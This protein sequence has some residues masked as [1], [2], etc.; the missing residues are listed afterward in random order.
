M[1][2]LQGNQRLYLL[3]IKFVYG[4]A[5]VELKNTEKGLGSSVQSNTRLWPDL[6]A[7]AG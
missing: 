1:Q 6:R 5:R 2:L 3:I 7:L 4:N